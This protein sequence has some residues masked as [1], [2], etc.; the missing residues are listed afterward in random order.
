MSGRR[1]VFQR[2]KSKFI[3][4]DKV[5]YVAARM[6]HQ[7]NFETGETKIYSSIKNSLARERGSIAPRKSRTA[8]LRSQPMAIPG[9][10]GGFPFCCAST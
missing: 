3:I 10:P 6:I 9:F 4:F 8:A 2:G 1:I 7:Q 5:C